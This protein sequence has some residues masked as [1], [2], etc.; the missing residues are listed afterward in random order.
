[1]RSRTK[2]TDEINTLVKALIEEERMR[3]QRSLFKKIQDDIIHSLK[4]FLERFSKI[5]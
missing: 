2:H 4:I 5:N 1:M 3:D